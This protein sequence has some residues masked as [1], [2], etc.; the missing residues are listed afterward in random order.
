MQ[1]TQID[2]NSVKKL[3]CIIGKN[4]VKFQRTYVYALEIFHKNIVLCLVPPD[5]TVAFNKVRY[6]HDVKSFVLGAFLEHRNDDFNVTY[7]N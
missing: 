4:F 3:L 2:K 7:R 1:N 5:L 6:S